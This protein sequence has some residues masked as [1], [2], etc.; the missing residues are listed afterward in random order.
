MEFI[1]GFGDTSRVRFENVKGGVVDILN[2]WIIWL[3]WMVNG[4]W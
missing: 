4:E 1:D 2:R 3:L